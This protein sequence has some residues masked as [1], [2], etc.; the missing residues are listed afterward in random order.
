MTKGGVTKNDVA[1]MS[2]SVGLDASGSLE[3]SE[4][5]R[6]SENMGPALGN[7]ESVPI[8]FFDIRFTTVLFA[9]LW[10]FLL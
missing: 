2:Y 5:D 8:N 6:L 7:S 3:F 4:W 1:R 10:Y 9:M